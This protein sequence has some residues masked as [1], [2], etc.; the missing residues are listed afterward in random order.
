[1]QQGAAVVGVVVPGVELGR[2]GVP[3]MGGGGGQVG[4]HAP[5]GYPWVIPGVAP[6]V[7]SGHPWL[8]TPPGGVTPIEGLLATVEVSIHI[9]VHLL[10]AGWLV[11]HHT[12]LVFL[13]F[14]L[15]FSH[16]EFTAT[17]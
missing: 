17:R 8:G 9:V 14:F 6:G 10:P 3:V 1:M 13:L 7:P 4:A 5:V 2:S 12:Y 15:P 16:F 11:K